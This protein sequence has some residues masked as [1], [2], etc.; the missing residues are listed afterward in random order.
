MIDPITLAIS[1]GP[2]VIAGVASYGGVKQ[3]LNG[4]RERVRNLESNS[5]THEQKD[6]QRHIEVVD[7]LARIETEI[8]NL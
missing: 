8:K 7:R 5:A 6:Q 1:L 2:A 3:A 4:T